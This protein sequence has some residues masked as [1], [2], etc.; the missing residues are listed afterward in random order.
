MLHLQ[1][2]RKA[3]QMETVLLRKKIRNK[4]YMYVILFLKKILS[5]TY[6]THVSKDRSSKNRSHSKNVRLKKMRIMKRYSNNEKQ[7]IPCKQRELLSLSTLPEL[8]WSVSQQ[9][10]SASI[11][12]QWQ[13]SRSIYSPSLLWGT[14]RQMRTEAH[15]HLSLLSLEQLTQLK[16]R[17]KKNK[18]HVC[19]VLCYL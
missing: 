5:I 2:G 10:V 14:F 19:Q 8:K 16:A 12:V 9:Q 15:C 17:M 7:K 4:Y 3:L 6:T 1:T 13:N 18:S 11:C